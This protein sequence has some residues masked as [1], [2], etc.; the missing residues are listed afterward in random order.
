VATFVDQ[1]PALAGVAV[2]AFATIIAT[3]FADRVR[4]RRDQAVRWDERRLEAYREYAAAIKTMHALTMRLAANE[5]DFR[6]SRPVDPA[7]ADQLLDETDARRT[8]MWESV[9]LLGDAATVNAARRWW[10]AVRALEVAV[11]RGPRDAAGWESFLGSIH[12]RRDAFYVAAR[13]SLG[14]R[15]GDVGQSG[16]LRALPPLREIEE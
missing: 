2:G 6:H 16:P 10:E 8:A 12:D 5:P 15:G 1:I 11:R 4:W 9:L 14:V 13:N 7:V 3:T